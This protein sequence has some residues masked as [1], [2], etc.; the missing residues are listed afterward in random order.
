MIHSEVLLRM[1]Q[2]LTSENDVKREYCRLR[3]LGRIRL[4]VHR[5]RVKLLRCILAQINTYTSTYAAHNLNRI[6]CKLKLWFLA[7]ISALNCD[8]TARLRSHVRLPSSARL[9]LSAIG[10]DVCR[11]RAVLSAI[12]PDRLTKWKPAGLRSAGVDAIRDWVFSGA[13]LKQI[14]DQHIY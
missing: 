7:D 14:A 2:A 8:T 4:S 3:R 10:S 5:K 9:F 6:K 13:T 12:V 11:A 1:K